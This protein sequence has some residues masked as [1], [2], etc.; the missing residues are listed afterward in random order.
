M[1]K[2][3]VLSQNVVKEFYSSSMKRVD[4]WNLIWLD[5]VPPAKTSVL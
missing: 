2:I 1:D 4:W 3:D 5:D